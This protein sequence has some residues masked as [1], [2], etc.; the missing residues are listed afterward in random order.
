MATH[1]AQRL[2][3]MDKAQ[4]SGWFKNVSIAHKQKK[5]YYGGVFTMEASLDPIYTNAKVLD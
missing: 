1:M 4:L 3:N 2:E 5:S